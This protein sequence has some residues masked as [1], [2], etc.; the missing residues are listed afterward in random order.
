MRLYYIRRRRLI[1]TCKWRPAQTQREFVHICTTV[2][3]SQRQN[4]TAFQNTIPAPTCFWFCECRSY[5]NPLPLIYIKAVCPFRLGVECVTVGTRKLTWG[6]MH[7]AS[8]TK[9]GSDTTMFG[10]TS[11]CLLPADTAS[12]NPIPRDLSNVKWLHSGSWQLKFSHCPVLLHLSC[13]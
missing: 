8:G 4:N 9:V 1:H 13:K 3:N 10:G 6:T 2:S 12:P 7:R 11:P 5:Q